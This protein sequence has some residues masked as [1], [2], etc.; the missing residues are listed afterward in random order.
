MRE[1]VSITHVRVAVS[2]LS[3]G[4]GPR[5][6][7]FTPVGVAARNLLYSCVWFCFLSFFFFCCKLPCFTSLCRRT[8]CVNTMSPRTLSR[9]LGNRFERQNPQSS[10]PSEASGFKGPIPDFQANESEALVM[11]RGGASQDTVHTTTTAA[12]Q[13][14]NLSKSTC[15]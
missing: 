4:S 1:C 14:A 6:P 15:K 8:K 7:G 2:G 11:F 10:G 5:L 13:T 9:F 12:K 3:G